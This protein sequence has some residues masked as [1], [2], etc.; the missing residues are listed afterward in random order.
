MSTYLKST[1]LLWAAFSAGQ[2]SAQQLHFLDSLIT[3]SQDSFVHFKAEIEHFSKRCTQVSKK[4][5][6]K[7]S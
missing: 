6:P 2:L 4:P 1:S 3:N 5:K 7:P